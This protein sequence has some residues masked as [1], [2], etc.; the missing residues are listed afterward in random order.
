[1][2]WAYLPAGLVP[3][4]ATAD[5]HRRFWFDKFGDA[6]HLS[7]SL[8]WFLSLGL[9]VSIMEVALLFVGGCLVVRLW[10]IRHSVKLVWLQ[11]PF[12]LWILF[13]LWQWLA[14]TWSNDPREGVHLAGGMRFAGILL[15]L[16][17]ML[18]HK[19]SWML[20]LIAGFG[21]GHLGQLAAAFDV[22]PEF[23][24]KHTSS[25]G[26][27]G[28]W[29]P[30]VIGGE[31]L[32]GVFA[33]YVGASVTVIWRWQ[34]GVLSWR[35]ATQLAAFI[36]AGGLITLA[37]LIAT[38]TRSAWISAIIM[39]LFGGVVS[40]LG[41]RRKTTRR[42]ALYMLVVGSL[43][44]GAMGT[45]L[46]T[47]PSS[48]V[49]ARV[50]DARNELA[51]VVRDGEYHTN[52]GLRIKMVLWAVEMWKESPIIGQG[53]GSYGKY[54]LDKKPHTTGNELK[55][56][57][58][59]ESSK[60]GHA[61]NMFMQSLATQGVIGCGLLVVAIGWWGVVA[62]GRWFRDAHHA[63][64]APV[65]TGHTS[66]GVWGLLGSQFAAAAPWGAAGLLLIFPFDVVLDSSQTSA[67]FFTF[68]AMSPGW[69]PGD[70]RDESSI[71]STQ[72]RA[73]P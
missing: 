53:T 52:N 40:L 19:G 68:L 69:C 42:R 36:F 35:R 10:F 63:H 49:H 56:V 11:W 60:H 37:G 2:V 44:A 30:E 22:L 33:L 70:H 65:A 15:V 38:G 13:F 54:V 23:L 61:H 18:K 43:S 24:S 41:I 4:V 9:P 34:R 72:R 8:I 12:L 71:T 58:L 46:A 47:S 16:Y 7:F 17:P 59:F 51:R 66:H 25:A 45:W 1:M 14:V 32:A 57:E 55:A 50:V 5:Y 27:V 39:M 21:L 64:T 29:W 48:P 6:F 3:S 62:T 31:M 26:R 28:G 20:A 73:T 67:L